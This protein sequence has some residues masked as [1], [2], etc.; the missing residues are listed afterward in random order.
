MRGKLTALESRIEGQAFYIP[1]QGEL[2]V[3]RVSGNDVAVMD[4]LLSRRHCAFSKHGESFMVADKGSSNG[5]FVNDE[6]KEAVALKPGDRVR[7][8]PILFEFGLEEGPVESTATIVMPQPIAKPNRQPTA[9]EV[10][11]TALMPTQEMLAQAKAQT[12]PGG[13]APLTVVMPQGAIPRN[14]PS[15]DDS[16]VPPTIELPQDAL[17]G[18]VPSEDDPGVPPTIALPQDVIAGAASPEDDSGVPPTIALSQDAI[19]GA[20]PAGGDADVPTT[21]VMPQSAIT[22]TPTTGGDTDVPTTIMMPRGAIPGSAAPPAQPGAGPTPPV[23]ARPATPAK[24][25]PPRAQ[26]PVNPVGKPIAQCSGCGTGIMKEQAS[27]CCKIE[28][29]VFCPKCAVSMRRIGKKLGEYRILNLHAEGRTGP[30]YKARHLPTSR[31]VA[32]KVL[33]AKAEQGTPVVKRFIRAAQTGEKLIHRNIARIYDT[34]I[35]GGCPYLVTEFVEGD[36]LKKLVEEG[37]PLSQK[38]A[39]DLIGTIASALHQAH[40]MHIVHRD[41]KPENIIVSPDGTP[42]IIDL[43]LAKSMDD[44]GGQVTAMGMTVGTPEYMAP[45]QATGAGDQDHRMDVYS[46]GATLYYAVAERPPFTGDRPVEVLKKAISQPPPPPTQFN[47]ALS[48]SF[49]RTLMTALAKKPADRFATCRQMAA[50][51]AQFAVQ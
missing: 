17:T 27:Q 50:A 47:P 7:I 30:L 43:G 35:V 48:E 10:A 49:V 38:R 3:G 28:N 32:I 51:L 20:V 34:G 1:E 29:R 18:A 4:P 23:P 46:L 14:G 25:Q 36:T 42:K 8:G 37:G 9:A 6:R 24:P 21:I 16:G 15:E 22:G 11:D 44:E 45:E 2:T 5:T 40:E 13:E 41:V 26:P 33:R 39:A 19:R 31:L 12:V